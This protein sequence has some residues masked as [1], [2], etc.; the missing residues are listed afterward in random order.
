MSNTFNSAEV[1]LRVKKKEA[2]EKRDKK[3]QAID[4]KIKRNKKDSKKKELKKG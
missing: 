1:F 4:I 2:V 3:K